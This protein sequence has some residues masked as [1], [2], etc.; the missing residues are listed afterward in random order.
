MCIQSEVMMELAS[1]EHHN[2]FYSIPPI[3]PDAAEMLP[4][5]ERS[6]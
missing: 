3:Y 6:E 4:N 5:Y 2:I 1:I